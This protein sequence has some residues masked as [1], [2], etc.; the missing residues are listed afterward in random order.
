MAALVHLWLPILLSAVVVFFASSI[1]HM[2][3]TYH[4][5]D[6][7]GIPDETAVMELIRRQNLAPGQYMFPYCAEMK[8]MKTE[9][10]QKKFA[11]GPI[12][13]LTIRQ[14]GVMNMGPALLQWFLYCVGIS[15]FSA[16]LASHAL[17]FGTPYLE[18]FRIVGTAAW[19]G[20][21][22]AVISAGIWQGRPWGV[23]V[24]DVLDGLLY[25]LLTAGVFGW[26][27]PR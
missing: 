26:L 8:E 12:G 4:R 18:V 14:A 23:V 15:L 24:K 27:W 3:F 16:Y 10:M 17:P 21:S 19:L 2:V 7:K 13:I 5:K 6:F 9:A 11:Q 1:V 22:G 25:A 20:Y